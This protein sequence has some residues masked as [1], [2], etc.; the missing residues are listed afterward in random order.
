[1]SQKYKITKKRG[2]NKYSKIVT[3]EQLD[4]LKRSGLIHSFNVFKLPLSEEPPLIQNQDKAQDEVIKK[5]TRAR[6]KSKKV[7]DN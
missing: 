3:Q 6:K 4:G 2:H 7:V 5:T 1:M